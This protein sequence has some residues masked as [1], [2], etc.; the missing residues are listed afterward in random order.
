MFNKIEMCML[1]GLILCVGYIVILHMKQ[2]IPFLPISVSNC[3]K[4]SEQPK[5]NIPQTNN[6]DNISFLNKS[7]DLDSNASNGDESIDNL[8]NS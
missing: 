5:T 3:F 7:Y 2:N 1:T 4:T 6:A 8:L